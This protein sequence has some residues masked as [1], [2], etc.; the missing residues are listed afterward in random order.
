MPKSL[1]EYYRNIFNPAR[2]KVK[3][4]QAEMPKKYW[5]N[6]PEAAAIPEMIATAEA[7]ARA[8]QAAA[9]TLAPARARKITE[10]LRMVEDE[11]AADDLE[12]LAREA[13][14]CARCPLHRDATQVVMGEGPR[15]APLMIVGE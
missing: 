6:L 2:L 12:A 7:R 1:I 11:P 4:M 9:P 14:G 15:E 13:A 10:R 8:M 5:K 3:A